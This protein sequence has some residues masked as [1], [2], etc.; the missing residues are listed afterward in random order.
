MF[1]MRTGLR[2]ACGLILGAALLVAGL[3]PDDATAGLKKSDSVV[4]VS[5]TQTKPDAAGKQTVTVTFVVEKGWHIYANPVGNADLAETRTVVEIKATGKPQVKVT[6][7]AGKVIQDK[8]VGNYRVYE[9]K[10]NVRAAVVRA[11]GDKS[12]LEVSVRFS[13]CNDKGCLPPAS[14]KVP[15]K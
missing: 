9:G 3:V 7:P 14:I 6:Y 12:P 10:V 5:A 11:N 4:K 15:V 2:L 8:D 1:T 13:A